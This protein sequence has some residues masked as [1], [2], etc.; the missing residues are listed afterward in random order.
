MGPSPIQPEGIQEV[1]AAL[2]FIDRRGPRL[3]PGWRPLGQPAVLVLPGG[4]ALAIGLSEA[5]VG[6]VPLADGAART[7]GHRPVHYSA[8]PVGAQAATTGAMARSYRMVR[9]DG[10]AHPAVLL[11]ELGNGLA[12]VGTLARRLFRGQVGLGLA[13]AVEAA[14]GAGYDDSGPPGTEPDSL[15]P[16]PAGLGPRLPAFLAD[17]QR[18]YER[19]PET[20]LL[21]NVL[22]NLEGRLLHGYLDGD[23]F[24]TAAAGTTGH[25]VRPEERLGRCLSLVRRE[26]YGELAPRLVAYERRAEILEGLARYVE[27]KLHRELSGAAGQQASKPP[28]DAGDEALTSFESRA[29]R[30]FRAGIEVL[31]QLNRRG[32]GASWRR[33]GHSGMGLAFLLDD[34]RPGWAERLAEA[35]EPLDQLL[36]Q[37][38]GFLGDRADDELIEAARMRYGYY[39]QLADERAWVRETEAR[40]RELVGG[41]LDGPGTRIV[42]D[43]S[44]LGDQVRWH[45]TCPVEWVGES[46]AVHRP[47]GAL[48]H[49]QG[50]T[51]VEYPGVTLVQDLRSGMLHVTVPGPALEVMGDDTVVPETRECEFSEGLQ[52]D[53]GSLRVRARRGRVERGRGGLLVTILA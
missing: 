6:F 5:P 42:L 25:P 52:V 33:F 43:I 51:Y 38:V 50:T 2:A 39:D 8:G 48:T 41:A 22:A 20:S 31:P 7:D 19:Y 21:N 34:A 18:A 3:W 49:A 4:A 23:G 27:L 53:L 29:R 32:W 36:E 17:C 1:L 37:A 30:L 45:D 24:A 44:A 15:P 16:G 35:R 11:P 14:V 9:L 47:P 26:R 28:G 12:A 46:V 40:R 13:V 10:V